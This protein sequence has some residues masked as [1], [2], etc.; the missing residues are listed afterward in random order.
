MKKTNTQN[1]VSRV[2]SS[3][4]GGHRKEGSRN[5]G[6]TGRC[7]QKTRTEDDRAWE[8]ISSHA[9]REPTGNVQKEEPIKE[10]RNTK[11]LAVA[12]TPDPTP[13]QEEADATRR[14]VKRVNTLT[15]TLE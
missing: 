6:G 15:D 2:R 13:C 4:K 9:P 12:A 1:A 3:R 10:K 8:A 5:D 14:R 11:A 7:K